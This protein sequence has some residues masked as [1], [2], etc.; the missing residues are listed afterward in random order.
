MSNIDPQVRIKSFHNT[1]K[2]TTLGDVAKEYKVSN[3]FVRH[4]N[5]LSL[6]YGKIVKKDIE[7]KKGLLPA[8]FD[9]YQVIKNNIIVFRVTDLQNDKKSL[10]VGISTQEGI[11][12]PAYVCVECDEK[13][14]SPA[15]L[16]TLLH[17]YDAITKVM[18]KM[19]DGLRQTLSYNDL[20]DL[21]IYIPS[22]DEQHCITEVINQIDTYIGIEDTLLTSLKQLKTASLQSMFPQKGELRPTVRFEGFED[23]WE[24][25]NLGEICN[26]VKRKASSNSLAPVMMISA[27]E[28]FIKQSE[29]YSNDNAGESLANYTLLKQGELAYN[30]G[31]SKI[32]KYGSCFTLNE[33]EARVPF[34][35][36][37]F[38]MPDDNTFFWGFYLNCGILDDELRKLVSST[39]RMDGLLNI[40]YDSYMS[41]EVLRPT[42]NEQKRI[43]DFFI[44]L[45]KQ[46]IMQTRKVEKL[47]QIKSA[48][49]NKMFS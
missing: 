13:K 44:S 21:V 34:V 4:Q 46:I 7:S 16:Y 14:V 26:R 11:I 42:K 17:Y 6:S 18:Y 20:K 25:V 3:K 24:K 45:D 9:T 36:H 27:S 47:K 32:R 2:K 33:K 15:Y 5:L 41:I 31:C 22:M 28:G 48:Y 1:W 23:D 10:R 29:K 19:G 38:N 30:H 12:T 43:A 37:A 39:A 49:L 35:Y 8:S 40:S